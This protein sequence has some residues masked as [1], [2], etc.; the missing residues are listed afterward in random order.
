M[1]EKTLESPLDCQEIKS[2]IPKGNQSRILIGRTDAKA[3]ALILWP[4]DVKSR[5][6]GKDPDAGKDARGEGSDRG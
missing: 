6:I 3:E 5:F 1:L 4:P 2:V